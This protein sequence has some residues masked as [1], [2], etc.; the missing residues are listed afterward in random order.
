[1]ARLNTACGHRAIRIDHIGST[2]VPGLDAKDVIDIQ[3]TVDSL[4]TA[5]ELA[6]ALLTAGYPRVAAITGDVAETRRPQHR[7]R[8]RPHR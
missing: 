4:D 2:A 3:V 6:D 1:M 8:V 5:D 7:R